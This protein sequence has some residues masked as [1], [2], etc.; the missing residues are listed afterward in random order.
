MS[1][2]RVGNFDIPAEFIKPKTKQNPNQRQTIDSYT[3][4]TGVTR[5]FELPHTKTKISFTT[6]PMKASDFRMIMDGIRENYISYL[7]RDVNLRYYDHE[8]GEFKTGH[9][10]F[11]QSFEVAEEEEGK[12]GIPTKYGEMT[13]TFIE[14]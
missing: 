7:K 3:D 14:Y 10:Y 9:F 5:A 1:Q 13:W 2:Y 12:N 4:D 8:N 6:L 11:D